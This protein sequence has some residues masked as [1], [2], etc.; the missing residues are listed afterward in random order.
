MEFSLIWIS[1]A[2]TIE[3]RRATTTVGVLKI[4]KKEGLIDR[5]GVRIITPDA[6]LMTPKEFRKQ[7]GSQ[8]KCTKK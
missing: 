3:H 1:D 7:K 5:E 8:K 2:R 4:I 6:K